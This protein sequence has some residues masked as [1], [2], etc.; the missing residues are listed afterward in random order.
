MQDHKRRVLLMYITKVS[1]H[2]QATIAIHHALKSTDPLVEVPIIN[3]FG[4]TYPILEKVVNQA[5]MSVIKRTPKV[6]DVMYDNPK[7]VKNSSSLKNF[8][9]KTSH[10]KISKLFARYRPETVVCTQAF[11]CGMVADYKRAYNIPVTLIGV[12]T[13]FEPHSFWVNEGVDY[14]VVPTLEAKERMVAMGVNPDIIKIYGI[15]IKAKFATQLDK[16]PILERYNLDPEK[17]TILVMGGGQGLGP[18]KTT[19]KSLIHME[20]DLQV[21]VLAGKNE[22]IVNSLR[23]TA[24]K[25]DKKIMVCEYVNNVDELM[26]I[27]SLII[28]KPGGITTAECL[29]KGLPMV[30]VDPIPGQETRNT[31]FLIK[32]GVGIRIDDTRDIGEE[33]SLVLRTPERLANMRRAALAK[34]RPH[35]SLDIARL[36]LKKTD[37]NNG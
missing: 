9:H 23:R 17:P 11:P 28:S 5:Y 14:Y 15:P 10:K 31:D 13:D 34:A 29:A 6:W 19:V 7:I 33:I 35:A 36:I 26:E 18:I 4:Y 30:I 24:A 20:M 2:R 16:R 27:S 8:L 1:G 3:G 37:E 25:S 12:L 32:Q 21:I 22:K